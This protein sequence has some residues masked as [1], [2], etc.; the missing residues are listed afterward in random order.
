MRAALSFAVSVA[1]LV[2]AGSSA[3]RTQRVSLFAVETFRP[4]GSRT[5]RQRREL[6]RKTAR[7]SS[8]ETDRSARPTTPSP[9][10]TST[11]NHGTRSRH[12]PGSTRRCAPSS[13]SRSELPRRVCRR[14]SPTSRAQG[15]GRTCE[16]VVQRVQPTRGVRR[17]GTRSGSAPSFASAPALQT[18]H[19]QTY[20]H[21]QHSSHHQTSPSIAEM[22]S[23]RA[24]ASAAKDTGAGRAQ[25]A[26]TRQTRQARR[27]TS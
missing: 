1:R 18:S 5:A 15:C 10:G 3:A 27:L 12:A 7:A 11:R 6:T 4:R 9:R 17:H 16:T 19:V 20:P 26:R 2:R 8:R 24:C 14:H 25:H 21:D 22:F 13:S 23:P